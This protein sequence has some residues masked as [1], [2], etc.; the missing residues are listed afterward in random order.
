MIPTIVLDM[1]YFSEHNFIG[2]KI[3]GYH[4]YKC[5]LFREAALALKKV[6]RDLLKF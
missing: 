5:I 2:K 6:Q 4:N 1:R 3:D